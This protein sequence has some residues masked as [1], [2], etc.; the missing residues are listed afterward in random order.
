MLTCLAVVTEIEIKILENLPIRAMDYTLH[1]ENLQD[2]MD[3]LPGCSLK[4]SY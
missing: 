3:D 2:F 4:L 1:D